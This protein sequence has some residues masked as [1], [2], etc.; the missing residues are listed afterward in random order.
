MQ[1][2]ACGKILQHRLDTSLICRQHGCLFPFHTP[3]PSIRASAGETEHPTEQRMS[4]LATLAEYARWVIFTIAPLSAF[5]VL[6]PS[7]IGSKGKSANFCREHVR[8]GE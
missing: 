2:G 4:L 1:F 7:R 5:G 8:Q 3:Y 6:L